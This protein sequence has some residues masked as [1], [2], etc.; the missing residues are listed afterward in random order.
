M[1]NFAK[2]ASSKTRAQLCAV[3]PSPELRDR[4]QRQLRAFRG[5]AELSALS[6]LLSFR[7]PVRTGMNDGVV[8]PSDYLRVEAPLSLTRFAPAARIPLR[9]ELRVAVVL[10]DFRQADLCHQGAYRGFVFLNRPDSHWQRER[11]LQ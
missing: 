5:T 3:S 1:C 11:V 7:F 2:I 6:N 8:R 4:I 9:G 10:V